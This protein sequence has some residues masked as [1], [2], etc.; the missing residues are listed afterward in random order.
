MPA[1]GFWLSTVPGLAPPGQVVSKVVLGTR[2]AAVMADWAALWVCP[3][4]P[5]TMGQ[6]PFDT[7]RLTGVFGGSLS[8]AA[9]LC[10]GDQSGRCWLEQALDW[11]P[12]LRPSPLRMEPADGR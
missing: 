2:P 10:D 8:P 1:L 4:T 7:T 11:L 12:T 9:G 3:T 6:L 5:G